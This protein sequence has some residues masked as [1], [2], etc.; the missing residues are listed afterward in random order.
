MQLTARSVN[1]TL[2]PVKTSPRPRGDTTRR[3]ARA[4]TAERAASASASGGEAVAQIERAMVRIRRSQTRRQLGRS[5]AHEL[6][7]E[8]TLSRALV[9]DALEAL[10]DEAIEATVS[11]VAGRLGV[12]PSRASRLLAEAIR[13]GDARREVSQQDG[14]RSVLA[15]TAQGRRLAQVVRRG[16]QQRFGEALRG[17]SEHDRGELA[18][19]LTRFLDDLDAALAAPARGARPSAGRAARGTGA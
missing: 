2:L 7:A 3:Q 11:E 18:R 16:R 10:A 13:Q 15:L 19:L 9:V 4:A 17:W 12:D 6:G 1:A 14:R 5:L 8:V